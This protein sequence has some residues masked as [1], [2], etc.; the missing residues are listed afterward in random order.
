MNAYNSVLPAMLSQ[1]IQFNTQ[2]LYKRENV[3]YINAQILNYKFLQSDLPHD[4]SK[5]IQLGDE[6]A[7][8]QVFRQYYSLLCGFAKKYTADID[9]AE[10]VVQD[11][12]YNFWMKRASIDIQGSIKSYLFTAVRNTCLNQIKHRNIVANHANHVQWQE[13]APQF[14][15]SNTMELSELRQKI[16]DCIAK[17]P[18]ERKKIF[19]MNR[20]EG[21]KYREIADQLNISIKTVEAQMGKALKYLRESLA[22]YLPLLFVLY[23]FL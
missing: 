13:S 7:F 11:V 14:H 2:P 12:F 16:D 6:Q 3:S 15:D 17:M 1:G 21:L 20:H 10:E 9:E 22:D 5:Q 4:I 8:E 19:I 18:P 23:S